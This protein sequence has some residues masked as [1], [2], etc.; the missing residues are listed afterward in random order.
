M[1]GARRAGQQSS[2]AR[3]QIPQASQEL[4]Q[5]RLRETNAGTRVSA[6]VASRAGTDRGYY[7]REKFG[8]REDPQRARSASSW[9]M[10]FEITQS[11]SVGPSAEQEMRRPI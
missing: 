8:R 3:E 5:F 9:R 11:V 6:D 1:A 2:R 7:Y 10:A 4:A